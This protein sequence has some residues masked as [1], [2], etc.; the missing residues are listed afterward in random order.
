MVGTTTQTAEKT[1]LIAA[2]K[3]ASNWEQFDYKFA[4]DSSASMVE[5]PSAGA[6]MAYLTVAL[7]EDK[8]IP[9]DVSITGT[10]SEDGIVGTVGGVFEKAKA[11]R[12]AG[13]RLFMIPAGEARRIEK[14]ESGVESINLMQYARDK[15]GLY[16]IEV[17]TIEDVMKYAY[18]D[19][20]KIDLQSL[21]EEEPPQFVPKKLTPV[22]ELL[23]MKEIT[24][25]HLREAKQLLGEARNALSSTLIDDISII[26]RMVGSL[27]IA[28]KNIKTAEILF[29]QGYFY[30]S[31]NFAFLARVN[32][33]LIKDIAENPALLTTDSTVFELKIDLLKQEII[34]LKK[35]MSEFMPVDKL[36]WMVSA[37]QR[38][39]WAEVTLNDLSGGQTVVV[40][41]GAAPTSRKDAVIDSLYKFESARAWLV[42][43]REFFIAAQ[44]SERKVKPISDFTERVQELLV[45]AENGLTVLK[46]DDIDDIERR[47]DSAKEELKRGWTLAALYNASSA[48][49]LIEGR[50]LVERTQEGKLEENLR[51]R[52]DSLAQGIKKSKY[53]HVWANLYL[54]HARYYLEQAVYYRDLNHKSDAVESFKNGLSLAVLAESLFSASEEVNGFYEQNVTQ[55]VGEPEKP[56]PAA[57]KEDQAK[58]YVLFFLLPTVLFIVLLVML[59]KLLKARKSDPKYSVYEELKEVKQRQRELEENLAKG[60]LSQDDFLSES[61]RLS[62]RMRQLLRMREA[63]TESTFASDKFRADLLLFDMKA[64]DLRRGLKQGVLSPDDFARLVND[65]NEQIKQLYDAL[66]EEQAV[67]RST[68]A[69]LSSDEDDGGD[70]DDDDDAGSD[71][72]AVQRSVRKQFKTP[73]KKRLVSAKK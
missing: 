62:E 8:S 50:Q 24:K 25:K 29:D 44:A 4:I 30:S 41:S 54:D 21:I 13:M 5:G 17:S 11:A 52:L 51:S 35:Q 19:L 53:K 22:D 47:I 32:A 60:K 69:V 9:K 2:K 23:P 55:P 46:G 40:S 20:A 10:I 15:W 73:A 57:V 28:E 70:E 7:L 18:A 37:Q 66:A 58:W 36:E 34:D 12:D 67:R 1:A 16:V 31:A 48:L 33:L 14:L 6:A 49:A 59:L 42:V 38:L 3:Y 63:K 64:R 61:G 71:L 43:A 26:G 56:V 65:Y 72:A 45:K 39:G 27:N 68:K